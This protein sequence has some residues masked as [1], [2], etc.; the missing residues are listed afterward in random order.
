[1]S[2]HSK[3]NIF[4]TLFLFTL[5]IISISITYLL[6]TKHN[7]KLSPFFIKIPSF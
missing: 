2:K 7:N 5:V 1:M 3:N 4:F 6:I